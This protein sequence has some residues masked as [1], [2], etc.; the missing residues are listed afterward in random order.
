MEKFLVTRTF[1]SNCE[2]RVVENNQKNLRILMQIKL[3]PTE[4]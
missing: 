2:F 3:V 1:P 4:V